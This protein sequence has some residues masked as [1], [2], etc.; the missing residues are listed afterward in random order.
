MAL[1][2]FG[3]VEADQLDPE[4][5]GELAR[6]LGLADTGGTGKEEVADRLLRIAEA[7]ARHLDGGG[8][9]VD[10]R[11]LAEHHGL[12]IAIQGLQRILVV[13][14]H[15]LGRN[16]GDLGDDVLDLLGRDCAL[17]LGFGQDA[18]R[19]TGLVD[20]VDG[21]VRQMTVADVARGKLGGRGKRRRGVLD[22]VVILEARLQPA[23]D[24]H[25]LGDRGFGHVNLL[26]T[27]GKCV[28]FL[29]NATIFSVRSGPDAAQLTRRQRRLQ[30]VGRIQRAA[31]RRTRADEGM[32][33]VDE[34]DRP[35]IVGQLLQHP[36][37]A[38][39]EVATVLGPGQQR[40]HVERV[41]R[42]L[43]QDLRHRTFDDAARQPLGDRGLADPGFTD[44]QRVVLPPPAQGLDHPLQ[45]IVAADQGIDLAG[46]GLDVEILREAVERGSR[47][48]FG[49]RLARL[50]RPKRL[51]R[52]RLGD[53]VGDEIDDVQPGHTLLAEEIHRV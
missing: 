53:A 7:T 27:P 11:V 16:P 30:Q 22:A 32:D 37:E 26:E 36:L 18:L 25:G 10:R 43:R 51:A 15:G 1:H 40:A 31:R 35:G 44:Q 3:H 20:D 38:L 2:V 12:E 33:L 48:R 52:R 28:I 23:Q 46:Q 39:L 50:V 42:A 17:L 8:Q 14:R 13:G 49:A 45:F 24:R 4:D 19:R 34:Q 41:D 47:R 29:E 6:H 5:I 9:R 21:L